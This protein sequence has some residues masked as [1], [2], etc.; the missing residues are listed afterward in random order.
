MKEIRQKAREA[1]KGFC[2]VCKVCDGKQC[3]SGVPGMGGAGTGASFRAN[4]EALANVRLNMNL[5]HDVTDPELGCSLLGKK[6]AMPVLA[7][8]VA[9]T[10]FNMG[11]DMSEEDYINAILAGCSESGVLGGCGDGVPDEIYQAGLAAIEELNGAGLPFFKPW[12]NSELFRKL[13]EAKTAG[14]DTVGMDIDAI[15]LITPRLMGRPIYPKAIEE[16]KHI[17]ETSDLKMILKGIMTP[18]D[19][20]RALESGASAIVVS[21]H[22]GR[23][24]DHCPGTAEV[25]PAIAK[26]VDGRMPVLVDGG[27]RSGGDVLKMLALGADAVLIGRPL[28]WAAIGGGKEG[29]VKYLEQIKSELISAMI[30]TGCRD[31][32]AVGSHIIFDA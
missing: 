8:P 26:A 9:G 14:A 19:A 32:A 4:S 18:D 3:V 16:L 6:L 5:I 28:A 30:L 1:M 15:G 20:M 22:G 27:V 21:N 10:K 17:T 7:A 11:S 24:L 23:V 31:L 13:E 25:L 29:V 12:K 2:R